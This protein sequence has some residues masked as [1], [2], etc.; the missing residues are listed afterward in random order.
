MRVV[1][2][3]EAKS[4]IKQIS[5]YISRDSVKH[6]EKTANKI[7]DKINLL[8]DFPYIG[9][10]VPEQDD[11]RYRELIYKSYRII[12][13]IEKNYVH[14]QTVLHGARNLK[15]IFKFK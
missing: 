11:E 7:H 4:E 2:D 15:N 14:I 9:R 3:V 6:A 5:D 12:Y 1:I 8:N 10:K 13:K